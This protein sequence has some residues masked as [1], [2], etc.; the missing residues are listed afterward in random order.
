MQSD[1]S[2]DDDDDDTDLLSVAE[3]L[4]LASALLSSR[5]NKITRSRIR[6]QQHVQLLL[7]ENQF[8]VMYRMSLRSFNKLLELL[9]PTLQLNER[10]G[11]LSSGEPIT[12][13]NMLHCTLRF[14]AGGSYHDIRQSA[15]ISKASFYRIIWH[16]ITTINNCAS[17]AIK[18]PRAID[19]LTAVADG[20]KSKSTGEGAMTGCV[21]SLDGFLLRIKAPSHAE[22][23]N[24]PA[25][26]SGHYCCYGINV[27]AMCD[28]ECRLLL[29]SLAGPGKSND[30]RAIKKTG[31]LKWIEDLPPG[32]FVSCDCAYSI[33]E[34]LLG[35]YSGPE[36]FLEKNDSFNFYLSQL[37]IRIEMCFGLMVTKWRILTMPLCIRLCNVPLLFGDCN[38][39]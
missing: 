3:H 27:Q 6:W 19:E 9:S 13:E 5:N 4:C 20:F 31:L 21:G 16:T 30:A 7:H 28:S 2:D 35:P 15:S 36:R 12:C 29:H 14:L 37:R 26:Y 34:H 25:Y 17:L 24:V 22:C 39:T 33:T 8:H 1:S 32:Y 38:L 18:L 11:M 23:G 10:F